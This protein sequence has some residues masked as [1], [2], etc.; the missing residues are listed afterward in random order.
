[1]VFTVVV[2]RIIEDEMLLETFQINGY[3]FIVAIL[4]RKNGVN[5]GDSID[6]N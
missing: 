1:M 2:G 6:T 5:R 3:F 4:T